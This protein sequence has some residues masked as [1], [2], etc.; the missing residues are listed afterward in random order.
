[1]G[2]AKLKAKKTIETNVEKVCIW[3]ANQSMDWKDKLFSEE[4]HLESLDLLVFCPKLL[5]LWSCGALS[6]HQ[7]QVNKKKICYS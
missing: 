5:S 7:Q 2:S 1:M 4:L 6:W 3:N